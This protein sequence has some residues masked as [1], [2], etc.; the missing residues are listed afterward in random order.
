MEELNINE[1]NEESLTKVIK[2]VGYYGDFSFVGSSR[3]LQ[4]K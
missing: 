3:G 1:Q 2:F 4:L